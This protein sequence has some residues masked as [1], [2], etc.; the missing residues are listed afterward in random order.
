MF[1]AICI[2]ISATRCTHNGLH[3]YRKWSGRGFV[4]TGR[5]RLDSRLFYETLYLFYSERV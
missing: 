2:F 5:F 3:N 1:F 4:K